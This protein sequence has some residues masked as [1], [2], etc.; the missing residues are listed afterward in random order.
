MAQ[1]EKCSSCIDSFTQQYFGA[2]PTIKHLA[3]E[4]HAAASLRAGVTL[5]HGLVGHNIDKKLS[6]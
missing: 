6:M 4:M 1:A 5:A 2:G 3:E